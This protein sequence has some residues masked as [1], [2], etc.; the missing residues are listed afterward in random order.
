M[1]FE[2]LLRVFSTRRTKKKKKTHRRHEARHYQHDDPGIIRPPHRSRH[3]LRAAPEQMARR[4]RAQ[5]GHRARQEHQGWPPRRGPAGSEQGRGGRGGVVRRRG[6]DPGVFHEGGDGPPLEPD[7]GGDQRAL[8]GR[9]LVR[10]VLGGL[11][12]FPGGG[13]E[14]GKVAGEVRGA[15]MAVAGE[16]EA[17][18]ELLEG[19][20]WGHERGRGGSEEKEG[21]QGEEGKA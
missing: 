6:C 15:D 21:K 11:E 16:A 14:R 3:V 19:C 10:F 7:G 18:L 2:A 20:R 9:E 4:G 8:H 1:S 17:R 13:G 12:A 5:A